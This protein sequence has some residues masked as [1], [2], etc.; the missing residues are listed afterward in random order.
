MSSAIPASSECYRIFY[1]KEAGG[2]EEMK[3]KDLV[4]LLE[5]C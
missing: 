3:G 1:K 5:R 2:R 4:G